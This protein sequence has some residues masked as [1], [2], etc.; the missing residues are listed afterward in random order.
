ML[1]LTAVAFAGPVDTSREPMDLE[2]AWAPSSLSP[3]AL[4]NPWRDQG[5]DDERFSRLA[6]RFQRGRLN[7]KLFRKGYLPGPDGLERLALACGMARDSREG[8]T[9]GLHPVE[10]QALRYRSVLGEGDVVVVRDPTP[11]REGDQAHASFD[12][13]AHV[14]RLPPNMP[15]SESLPHA[16]GH[17][18][19]AEQFPTWDLEQRMRIQLSFVVGEQTLSPTSLLVDGAWVAEMF[20]TGAQLQS[21]VPLDGQPT[22]A[23]APID[24]A[25]RQI[26]AEVLS[27]FRSTL[28]RG[29]VRAAYSL[30]QEGNAPMSADALTVEQEWCQEGE[31]ER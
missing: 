30:G 19:F 18:L 2:L 23:S 16:L 17:L 3:A 15:E 7:F 10:V 1:G 26:V 31:L 24:A 4:L 13:A 11:A 22:D 29:L 12:S 6:C 8:V 21:F 14:L 9:F 25:L 20:A 27:P 5:I 28:G